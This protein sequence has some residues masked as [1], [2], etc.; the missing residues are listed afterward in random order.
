MLALTIDSP[1]LSPSPVNGL[2]AARSGSGSALTRIHLPAI[3]ERLEQ[4]VDLGGHRPPLMTS[5]GTASL[6]GF[7]A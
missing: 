6:S 7:S 3:E 5:F 4:R 1:N 2:R